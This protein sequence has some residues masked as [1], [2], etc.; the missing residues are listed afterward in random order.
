MGDAC[1]PSRDNLFLASYDTQHNAVGLNYEAM[2]F[3]SA[4]EHGYRVVVTDYIGMGTP[5]L[6][7]YAI[8]TEEG[9]ALIDAAR[10][11]LSLAGAP[12][13][14]PVGF[15][16]YSQGGGS[17]ASAAERVGTYAP[18]INLKGTYSG[19]PPAAPLAITA[20]IEQTIMSPTAGMNSVAIAARSPE[21]KRLMD[22]KVFNDRGKEYQESLAN[23][24]LL[25]SVA[26]WGT[27]DTRSLTKTGETFAQVLT[28]E[29]ELSKYYAMPAVGKKPLNAPMMVLASVNDDVIPFGQARDMAASYC[30]QG[31]TVKFVADQTPPLAKGTGM[32]HSVAM[33]THEGEAIE[34]LGYRF[35]DLTP[36]TSCS[37]LG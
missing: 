27:V 18:E 35:Q 16:G 19:A 37:D 36:P 26:K 12:A 20:P 31:G 32:N 34:H 25:D 7:T 14:D 11:A 4:L 2:S 5:G 28:H 1:A 24:C 22:E 8:H 10:A 21:A 3:T 30:R 15:F 17:A 33:M 13:N 9:R 23:S 29:P 6:H